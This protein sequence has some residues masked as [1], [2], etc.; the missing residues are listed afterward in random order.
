L[1]TDNDYIIYDGGFE[2]NKNTKQLTDVLAIILK[3]KKNIK[4]VVTDK[5]FVYD[6]TSHTSTPQSKR[7]VDFMEY[8]KNTGVWGFV[9]AVGKVSEEE[10]AALTSKAKIYLNLSLYE[11]FGFGPLQAMSVGTPVIVSDRTS[12][13][14]VAGGGASIVSLS[15]NDTIAREVLRILNE[16]EYKEALINRG[17]ERASHF[18]W[19][20]CYT[21][22]KK[23]F[24]HILNTDI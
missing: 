6:T 5:E 21:Q 12:F 17:L 16:A 24:T 20:L 1:L 22:T 3:E 4:L 8:A 9:V 23:I 11:G 2:A 14:E 7:A 18:N 10:L 15:D 13:P 19:Q